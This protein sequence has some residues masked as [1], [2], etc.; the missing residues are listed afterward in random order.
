MGAGC[1]LERTSRWICDDPSRFGFE[2]RP[3]LLR[4]ENVAAEKWKGPAEKGHLSGA[5]WRLAILW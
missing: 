2:I 3:T 1:C 5:L 4:T